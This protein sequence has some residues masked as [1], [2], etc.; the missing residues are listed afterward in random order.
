[1]ASGDEIRLTLNTAEAIQQAKKFGPE[2]NKALSINSAIPG[3]EKYQKALKK[4]ADDAGIISEKTGKMTGAFNTANLDKYD[5]RL[6]KAVEYATQLQTVY[7]KLAKLGI[8]EN[9]KGLKSLGGKLGAAKRSKD[10]DKIATAQANLDAAKDLIA[11]QAV[12]EDKLQKELSTVETIAGKVSTVTDFE[13]EHGQAVSVINDRYTEIEQKIDS[14]KAS[15]ESLTEEA[16]DTAGAVEETSNALS[17]ANEEA[18]S[19]SDTIQEVASETKDVS[20]GETPVKTDVAQMSISEL[21]QEL[22]RLQ[23]EYDTTKQSIDEFTNKLAEAPKGSDTANELTQELNLAKQTLSETA[24]ETQTVKTA[25]DNALSMDTAKMNIAELLRYLKELKEA[26]E[27]IDGKANLDKVFS[28]AY[29]AAHRAQSAVS[30]YKR[31]LNDTT[32]VAERVQGSVSSFASN[33][34]KAMATVRK[35]G[36]SVSKVFSVIRN[37]FKSIENIAK[38]LTKVTNK[39]KSAFDKMSRNMRSNFKHLISNLTKYVFGFRSLFFLVRRLRSGIKEGLQNLAQF[40]G[41]SNEVNRAISAL[42]SSVLYLKNAWA[43]AFSPIITYVT[44]VTSVLTRLIDKLAEAGNAI[45]RFIA[46]LTGQ[47]TVFQAVKVDAGDY[48]KSLQNAGSSAGGAAKKQ[49]QLN[50]RLAAFDD[51]NVLGKDKDPTSSGSGGG[52]GAGDLT[53]LDP[54]E[55][56]KIVPA[57]SNLADMIKQ[58]WTEGMGDFSDL[59]EVI[60]TKLKQSLDNIPWDTIQTTA[61]KLGR[62]FGSLLR[63]AF[64]VDDIWASIGVTLGESINTAIGFMHNFLT[65]VTQVDWGGGIATALNSS[66]K[67][68]DWDTVWADIQLGADSLTANINSLFANLDLSTILSTISSG[69]EALTSAIVT[70]IDGINWDEIVSSALLIGDAIFEGIQQGLSGSDN[71][72]FQSLGE[73]IGELRGAVSELA[74]QVAPLFSVLAESGGEVI[75]MFSQLIPYATK[76][77]EQILPQVEPVLGSVVSIIGS[78][79]DILGPILPIIGEL[80]SIVVPFIATKWEV[81]SEFLSTLTESLLPVFQSLLDNLQPVLDSIIENLLP[82]LTEAL[83]TLSPV[84]DVI[85]EVLDTIFGVSGDITTRIIELTG[86]FGED[87]LGALNPLSDILA[88]VL[89]LFTSL[90]DPIL[91]LLDPLFDLLEVCLDPISLTLQLLGAIL[92]VT[93]VPGLKLFSAIVK[94]VVVPVLTFL[95]NKIQAVIDIIHSLS[96]VTKVLRTLFSD[97]FNG[98]KSIVYSVVNAILGAVE[99]FANGIVRGFN[100][101]IDGLNS[102]KFTIP[103]W[104]PDYG[105]ESIGLNLSKLSTV[106]IPRLAQGAVIPPN[107]EFMAIL[108]DQSS[109]TNIEAPL[110]TI[111]QAVAEE[112]SAQLDVLQNGFASVVQAINNKDLNIGDKQIGMANARYNA[113]QNLIRGTSF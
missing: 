75:S 28:Q 4:A 26:M 71:P 12:L 73:L 77:F 6:E 80:A 56:F 21:V 65:E 17:G 95:V 110:D 46:T 33:T 61:D 97:T 106:S 81:F 45:A 10:A 86:A 66:I 13:N 76:F 70:L 60:G 3:V 40:A 83:N 105:G 94:A 2:L 15:E 14:S 48:A 113:R 44:C 41:G 8:S 63:G 32:T 22:E 25:L 85:A 102:I 82:L 49:K 54:N 62:T 30:N 90:L 50:D 23:S 91:D 57:V 36:Q 9:G 42:M 98:I 38:S 79:L 20:L 27:S 37:G 35:A 34:S 100:K 92:S 101:V 31:E 104:V 11:E 109:G 39:V 108:G 112:L 59:G 64:S 87:L 43:A 18:K 29:D 19:F 99:K 103:D 55:M 53:N 24:A 51:L 69:S 107:K 52:G 72:I 16:K 78:L 58:A 96:V 1:M 84:F 47:A 111:K 89:D 5:T 67:T 68:I 93:V 7:E 74:P 88:T